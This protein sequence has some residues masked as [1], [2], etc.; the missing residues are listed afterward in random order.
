MAL[1]T[2]EKRMAAA[3]AGRPF[4]RA[5][6]P[7]ATPDEEWRIS[8]GIAY[9]GN[10][11]TPAMVLID[12]HTATIGPILLSLASGAVVR[13]RVKRR[14]GTD[15]HYTMPEGSSLTIRGKL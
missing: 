13:L 15:T 2:Q 1:D 8:I 3:G 10:A 11:L 9:G 7:V 4:M 12:P 5:H 14:A 6:F